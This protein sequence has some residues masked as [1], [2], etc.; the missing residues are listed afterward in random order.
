[1]SEEL[2][3]SRV[4][5]ARAPVLDAIN[6]FVAAL[7]V[8]TCAMTPEFIWRGGS[9]ALHHFSL[10]TLV[11]ALLVGLMLAFC[12]EPALERVRHRW[13]AWR[14]PGHA[15]G[16][17][18]GHTH[19]LFTAGVGIAFGFATVCVHDAITTFL[20]SQ[21]ETGVAR[22]MGLLN[23][24][25]V[26]AN[27]AA[28]PFFVTIAWMTAGRPPWGWI[29]SAVAAVSPV[30]LAVGFIWSWQDWLTTQIPTLVILAAGYRQ[31]RLASD[32]AL[33]RRAAQSLAWICPLWFVCALA[34]GAMLDLVGMGW[35]ELYSRYEFWIDVR[36]YIGWAMGLLLVPLPHL[37][38]VQP[39]EGLAAPQPHSFERVQSGEEV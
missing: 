34:V 4:D 22:H 28:I 2:Q 37:P 1:V 31:A 3:F 16:R 8:A 21:A 19:L 5:A 18:I 14:D 15:T 25:G 38:P 20:A 35:A 23:G 36:F 30:V 32:P 27:W 11:S 24:L 7:W 17:H 39:A 12:I 9:A 33:F 29:F 10:I 13:L 26:A 6:I